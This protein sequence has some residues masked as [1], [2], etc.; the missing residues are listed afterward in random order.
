[1]KDIGGELPWSERQRVTVNLVRACWEIGYERVTIEDG[2]DY[3]YAFPVLRSA[4]CSVHLWNTVR[5]VLGEKFLGC[6]NGGTT[7]G[8][9]VQLREIS[10]IP[11]VYIKGLGH[12]VF[13]RK[14]AEGLL[15]IV[16]IL[17]REGSLKGI[18]CSHLNKLALRSPKEGCEYGCF[19]NWGL[20][21]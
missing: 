20:L 14:D 11:G 19:E 4:P 21:R 1:M 9:Q 7:R 6:G 13:G 17:L 15:S 2:G 12:P 5:S 16:E 18:W 10:L 3:V 8:D